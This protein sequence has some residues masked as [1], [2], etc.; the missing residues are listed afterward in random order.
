MVDEGAD[1]QRARW[2]GRGERQMSEGLAESVLERDD[3][4][5]TAVGSQ[6]PSS[7]G[8]PPRRHASTPAAVARSILAGLG[9]RRISAVYLWVLFFIVFTAIN[10]HTFPT[11]ATFKLVFSEGVVTCM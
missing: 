10:P 3:A 5:V 6:Q 4:T 8:V 2:A 7:N 11:S 1:A 9:P